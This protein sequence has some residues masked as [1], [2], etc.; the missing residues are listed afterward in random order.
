MGSNDF[1]MKKSLDPILESLDIFS[2]LEGPVVMNALLLALKDKD[3]DIRFLT[4]LALQ[5]KK[6]DR[7]KTFVSFRLLDENPKVRK[8]AAKLL[9]DYADIQVVK[10]MV[11][12]IRKYA[13]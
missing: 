10:S 8:S 7:I 5:G 6:D 11:D 12:A 4:L 2:E 3:P 9:E 1:S 13:D